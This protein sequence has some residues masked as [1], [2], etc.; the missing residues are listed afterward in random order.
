MVGFRLG[1]TLLLTLLYVAKTLNQL[2]FL[3]TDQLFGQVQRLQSS[4]DFF[5]N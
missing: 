1:G 5:S 4:L 3:W 2:F